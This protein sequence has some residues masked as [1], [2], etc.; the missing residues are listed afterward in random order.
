MVR[1][2]RRHPREVPIDQLRWKCNPKD[3]GI[4][5]TDDLTPSKEII[6]QDRAIR[7]IRLGLEMKHPGYNVFVTGFSGT[8]RMTTIKR[9]LADFKTRDVKLK[10][11]CYVHNFGNADQ[12]ILLTLPAGDGCRLHD[13]M[14]SMVQDLI[15]II[16]AAFERKRFKEERKRLVE[17]FQERQQSVLKDY[18]QK[19]KEKGFEVIQVQVGTMMRPDITPVVEEQPVSFEQLDVLIKEG[20]VSRERAEQMIRDRASLETQ[21]E[22]VM[23]ELRNIERKA[24]D[25][26]N[27]MAERFVFPIV[28]DCVDEV[29]TRF[30][31][32]KIQRWFE[33]VQKHIM[34]NLGRFRQHDDQASQPQIPGA[35][36]PEEPEEDAFLEYQVNVVV[37][38]SKTTGVP[39]VIE[40][41][42][43]FKN[44]FGTIEREVDRNGVWRTDF[45]LIKAGSLLKADGGFLVLNALDTL[46]EPGVWQM[47]KRTLRYSLVEIQAMETGIFGT[48]SAFKPE[49]IDVDVKVVMLGD[50]HIYYLLYDQDDDFKKV[51]KVRADFDTEMPREVPAVESYTGFIKMICDDEHL[52][53]FSARG[54]SS[55]IEYGVR[56]AD[57][58][59]KL[60]TRFNVVADIAREANYWAV[61]EGKSLVTDEHVRQALHERVERV[62]LTEEKVREMINE[63][64][65]MIATKGSV[66][67]QVNG[68]SVLDMRE[69]VF[70]IPSRITATTSIGRQGIIN[71]ERE[72]EMSGPSHNKGVLI[73][74]GYLAGMY[75]GNKPLTMNASITFEQNYSGVD[76]DSASSTEVYAILSSLSGVPIHQ[77]IAVTGSVNQ[78]GEIQP[79]GGINQKI[80]GFFET[81]QLRGLSGEHGV[82]IPY[83][84]TRNLMLN[85]DVIDAVSKG[86]FHI[87][88]IRTVDEGI[89]ILTGVKAGNRMP[90][91]SF[92][93]G[94]IHAAV[95][96]TLTEYARHWKTLLT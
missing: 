16:P 90:D 38:N 39:I 46:T 73:I 18:E 17:L 75:A 89:E 54:I 96:R 62:R 7:A 41:N 93:P 53:P 37:D 94:S 5:T 74:G 10:D 76:G 61:K 3:L 2:A 45:T 92:E 72:V 58:Q 9:I 30:T 63:D 59:D 14:E 78:K 55:I 40:T 4:K 71:I 70:G 43:R 88:S 79:I 95:D 1:K 19:V 86:L 69:H 29:R 67:G 66:V 34:D 13:D 35:P 82:M 77:S 44:L 26:L 68:L 80:E 52:R 31:D 56:L 50:A 91:G 12:P 33:E 24:K 84:N 6:G 23:R 28:K 36:P 57:Q 21:M 27:E 65:L 11:R 85:Q 20:K 64:M 15:R 32:P 42:P 83:Q 25:S 22:L 60:S 81:C 47:L 8:G 49:S 48:T 87:Y 51:F